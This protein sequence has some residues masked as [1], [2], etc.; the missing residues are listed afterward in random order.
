MRNAIGNCPRRLYCNAPIPNP[1]EQQQQLIH[2]CAKPPILK[3]PS[4]RLGT[5]TSS[6]APL[7]P[8]PHPQPLLRAE[9]QLPVQLV[10]RVLPVYEVAETASHAPLPAVQPAARL[11]EVCDRRE[12]AVDRPCGVPARVQLVARFLRRVFVLESRVHVS[13][14]I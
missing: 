14:Q 7:I 12:L 9:L 13:Y 8:A 2:R 3:P 11:A 4:R 5:W 6:L 1:R 10:A